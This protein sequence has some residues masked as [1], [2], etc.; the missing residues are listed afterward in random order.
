M[1]YEDQMGLNLERLGVTDPDEAAPSSMASSS[2]VGVRSTALAEARQNFLS[3]YRRLRQNKERADSLTGIVT[4]L[5]SLRGALRGLEDGALGLRLSILGAVIFPIT[6][7]AAILSMG[8]DFAAG[9]SKFWLL[10][11]VSVPLVAIMV[12]FLLWVRIKR[13]VIK[14]FSPPA[15]TGVPQTTKMVGEKNVDEDADQRRMT[16]ID[17]GDARG[18]TKVFADRKKRVRRVRSRRVSP[19]REWA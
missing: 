6:L 4:D 15:R 17:R 11:A 18:E 13:I 12:G 19:D 9:E 3:L 10:W 7:I 2:S 5:I 14:M 16:V 1:W 8:G